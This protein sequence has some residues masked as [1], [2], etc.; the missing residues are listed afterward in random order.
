MS[1]LIFSIWAADEK[2]I[3]EATG[4][5]AATYGYVNASYGW[6]T[7]VIDKITDREA[8]EIVDELLTATSRGYMFNSNKNDEEDPFVKYGIA[9]KGIRIDR[10]EPAK[11]ELRKRAKAIGE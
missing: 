1:K 11:I 7:I 8:L 9:V 6:D 4:A 2:K 10:N 5:L 3:G